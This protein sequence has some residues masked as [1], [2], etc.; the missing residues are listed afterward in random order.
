MFHEKIKKNTLILFRI[1]KQ[2]IN[3]ENRIDSSFV[4]LSTAE[5]FA[6]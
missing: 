4:N 6:M 1:Q 5:S 2:N 3:F